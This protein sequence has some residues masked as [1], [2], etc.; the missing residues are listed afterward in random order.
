MID[1]GAARSLI[2]VSQLKIAEYTIAGPVVKRYV[3]ASGDQLKLGKSLVNVKIVLPNQK[4]YWIQQVLVCLSNKPSKTILIGSPDIIRL[5]LVL[6][7][8]S[9]SIKITKG[10]L[11]NTSFKMSTVPN[12]SLSEL[13]DISVLETGQQNRINCVD[14]DECE[15]NCVD[16]DECEIADANKHTLTCS[17][18][19]E[20]I[21]NKLYSNSCEDV[22][23]CDNC[24]DI[25]ECDAQSNHGTC[26]DPCIYDSEACKGCE[27]CIDQKLH[28]QI[29]SD[30][31]PT[32]LNSNV[33]GKTALLSYIERLRQRDR[34]TH[35]HKECTIDASFKNNHPVIADKL[36]ILLEK[37]KDVFAGDIGKISE[38]YAVTG[39]MTGKSSPQRPGHSEF[40]GQTLQA[41][42]KQFSKLI[43]H[44]V[45]VN[46]HDNNI[47]PINKM[48]ILP[49]KKKDDDG[50]ILKVLSALRLVLDSRITNSQTLFCGSHT[51]NLNDALHFAARTSK[52]G[53]NL[54]ADIADAYYAIPLKR[55]LW[56][57]FCVTIPILGTYCFTRLVQGWAPAAQWCQ[58]ILTRIF[59]PLHNNLRKYMDD[60]VLSASTA[61]EYL[62][63]V[64]H[65]LK[66]CQNSNLRLKGKKCFFGATT[67][68]FLGH[69]INNGK[70]TASPHYVL[71]L[72]DI[73]RE[74]INLKTDL[75]SFAQSVA[76]LGKFSNHSTDLLAPLRE[77][78]KGEK[79]EKV[80][81]TTELIA[82]FNKVKLA[83]NELSELHPFD[84]SLDT[85][86]V[87]D[88]SKTA[89][90]GFMYQINNQ[91][92]QLVQFFSRARRDK[93]RKVP[94]S[95][96]HMELLGLKS[97]IIAL[98]YLL[99][100]CKKTIT[101]IT[102]SRSLV[103]IFE[104]YRKHEIPSHDT[105]LNNAMY[106]IL[107][108]LDVNV[109]HAKNT[110][111]NIK[112]ADDLSRLKI[113]KSGTECNGTPKCTICQAA[114]PYVEDRGAFINLINKIE[115]M[116]L[117]IGNILNKSFDDDPCGLSDKISFGK[118]NVFNPQKLLNKEPSSMRYTLQ[119]LLNDKDLLIDLQN[120]CRDLRSLR[121][122][123][124]Q[125]KVSYPKR[126][127]RLHTLLVTRNAKLENDII[128][129]DK[130]I[131]GV[132]Y[133]VIPLPPSGSVIA[134]AAIHNT[135]GHQTVSQLMQQTQRVFQFDDLK[136][137]IQNFAE[138]CLKCTLLKGGGNPYN[139]LN[140]K[141]VPLP[142]DFYQTILVDEVTR[143]FKNKN[144][145]FLLAMESLSGFITLINYE[146]SMTGPKFVQSMAQI[147][148]ILCPH[149]FQG[150]KVA[151]RCDQA[152]WHTSK[153]VQE[154]LHLMNIDLILYNSATMS[155]N[156]I[157]EL[158]AKIKIF[159][160]YL[161]QIVENNPWD[162]LTCC[163]A[164]V[165]KT[166]GA[167]GQSG[168]SPAD[169]FVGRSWIDHK[170]VQ[171]DTKKLLT[172]IAEKRK[173][174]R[175]YESQQKLKKFVQNET[176]LVPYKNEELN[177]SWVQN[178]AL[179]NLKP[180][181]HITIKDKINKN[182]PRCGYLVEEVNFRMKKVKVVRDSGR[183]EKVPLSQWISFDIIDRIFE[184]NEELYI[185]HIGSAKVNSKHAP[186]I[187]DKN[188]VK[189]LLQ[190]QNIA[191]DIVSAPNLN[192]SNHHS[193]PFFDND[194]ENND[195]DINLSDY[196][197]PESFIFE[198]DHDITPLEVD[199]N[200]SEFQ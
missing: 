194:F 47:I 101:V 48:S 78:S 138:K 55:E 174:R 109:I 135:I 114:N 83:L 98:L 14:I 17:I 28:E 61:P 132:T 19:N 1:T 164:A 44:G 32:M 102:D 10:A 161:A 94:L 87:V 91:N 36:N 137:K 129:I 171:I 92:P 72:K 54:K 4:T 100:Q 111:I 26:G 106:S 176:K 112:F 167:I 120:R 41:V 115:N 140:Q 42:I 25:D 145:K 74:S 122:S 70:I 193:N 52:S 192:Q 144:I 165:A 179:L 34:A 99:R 38:T 105:L 71:K 53:F 173:A 183:D 24:D 139:R 73:E 50:N 63:K 127:Q 159:G 196:S 130:I 49:V 198:S 75:R 15:T 146:K 6:D 7:Y 178:P 188:L 156:I 40:T 93:E 154:I 88:T 3:T 181:D 153:T 185:N 57:Y 126:L 187:S 30:I 69:T 136:R 119:Q 85:I 84:P 86:L 155:K 163:F 90:G 97:M 170:T 177:S 27:R 82:A 43:A 20:C 104:K 123:I 200:V 103:K 58:E 16:I 168:R 172:Q 182:Q 158:D 89:T 33:D 68:N 59:F 125:G 160:Q 186:L 142:Q 12:R 62:L 11:R 95:S 29:Q 21:I 124:Q 151:I 166:N 195:S 117:N 141:P 96:C 121:Q 64:E 76:Y 31:N 39:K 169:L 66:I 157:P 110:N 189:F 8:N 5:G 199:L 113:L 118:I 35:S 133:R 190:T 197:V 150:A 56:G 116:D 45:L 37:Y 80:E 152:T 65:F 13:A 108:V 77:A 128:K 51:D 79:K 2:H 22:D 60:L 46:A 18:N 184:Q 175:N 149:G 180:G 81:W 23:E 143:T 9:F 148:S 131:D 191:G 134:I 67:F 107:S 162:L 147:K